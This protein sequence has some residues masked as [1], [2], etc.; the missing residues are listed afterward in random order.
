MNWLEENATVELVAEGSLTESDAD[1][2]EDVVATIDVEAS[3]A[4]TGKKGNG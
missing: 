2:Q 4:D 3:D 1:T